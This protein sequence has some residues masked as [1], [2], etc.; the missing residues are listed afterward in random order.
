MI[1]EHGGKS[2]KLSLIIPAYD[3]EKTLP[4]VLSRV[5]RL[6]ERMDLEIIAVDDGSRDGTARVLE[7]FRPPSPRVAY[8]FLRHGENRGKGAAVR[9]AIAA[10]TGE[11]VVIQDADLEYD[12]AD[13][14]DLIA[15][16]ADGRADAVFGSR[17]LAGP[18]R[19]H[20]FWHRVGN[21]LVTLAANVL[22]NMNFTDIE[23]GYKAFRREVI[24]GMRLRSE[25]F[26][27]EPEI[28]AKLCRAKCRIYEIPVSYSG[29]G[30][31]EGK[32]ITWRDG[33]RALWTLIKYRIIN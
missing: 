29:R 24:Q 31:A 12:P 19:V 15:P 25:D 14:S 30:Y 27:I 1:A 7:G 28:T 33:I 4:D 3:E 21:A 8:R 13:I 5:C 23:T 10:A 16:I 26:R 9:T 22:Y 17:F 6:A 2:M 18:H 32:K 20:L 11:V